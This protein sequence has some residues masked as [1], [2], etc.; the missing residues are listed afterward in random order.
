MWLILALL[1]AVFAALTFEDMEWA[2]S[3]IDSID[4]QEIKFND[5]I[6]ELDN[7]KLKVIEQY[8]HN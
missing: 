4:E 8:I 5:N 6:K 1:S 7:S 2:N 3:C